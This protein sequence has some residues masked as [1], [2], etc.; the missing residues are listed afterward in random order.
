MIIVKYVQMV[1]F[2]V[3]TIFGTKLFEGVHVHSNGNAWVE[4]I[5]TKVQYLFFG[6]R[7]CIFWDDICPSHVCPKKPT[8]FTDKTWL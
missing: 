4:K 6:W 1:I 2:Y 5:V 8:F 3:R 7:L